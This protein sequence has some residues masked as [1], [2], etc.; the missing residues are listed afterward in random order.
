MVNCWLQAGQASSV[1]KA[2]EQWLGSA[3]AAD[4]EALIQLALD[5][6]E[7]LAGSQRPEEAK[8][9]LDL[10]ARAFDDTTGQALKDRMSRL[11]RQL[12]MAE[13]AS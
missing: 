2:V 8:A 4:R 12:G 5:A 6:T 10:A 13:P 11:R 7:Q 9:V 3:Q 1:V